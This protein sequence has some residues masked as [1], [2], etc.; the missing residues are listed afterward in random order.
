MAD[1][2][3]K[4]GEELKKRPVDENWASVDSKKGFDARQAATISS[5]V[6]QCM[7]AAGGKD[8]SVVN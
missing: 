1:A 3:L 4:E 5:T 8:G 6:A 2:T 7:A